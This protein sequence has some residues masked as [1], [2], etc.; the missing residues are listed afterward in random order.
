MLAV[1]PDQYAQAVWVTR[2]PAVAAE[3][4]ATYLLFERTVFPLTA[5]WGALF[6]SAQGWAGL[7]PSLAREC[8]RA[9]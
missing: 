3:A 6:Y 8:G 2:G 4:P 1:V 9:R 7:G 5:G